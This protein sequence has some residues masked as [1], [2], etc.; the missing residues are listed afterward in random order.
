MKTAILK[1]DGLHCDG[2]ARSV[3]A[4]VS[5]EPGVSNR[6]AGVRR[7]SSHSIGIGRIAV[8]KARKVKLSASVGWLAMTE[9]D[10]LGAP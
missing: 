10:A 7:Q 6:V 3:A 2:C 9:N 1:I 5:A 8:V 4:V